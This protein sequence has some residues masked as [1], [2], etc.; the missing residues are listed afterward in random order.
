MM[1]RHLAALDHLFGTHSGTRLTHTVWL[2]AHA[3][4]RGHTPQ[5]MA[6]PQ[7]SV[8]RN[9]W[10]RNGERVGGMHTHPQTARCRHH[11]LLAGTMM[12]CGKAHGQR[13]K[14]MSVHGESAHGWKHA[15]GPRL[16]THREPA[17]HAGR[18]L[19]GGDTGHRCAR[20]VAAVDGARVVCGAL[21]ALEPAAAAV[22]LGGASNGERGRC[23]RCWDR[24]LPVDG[25][26]RG[27][28]RPAQTNRHHVGPH[29]GVWHA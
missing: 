24:R 7:L 19:V 16:R 29:T 18:A 6:L 10:Q 3:K 2:A 25:G 28:P 20:G 23:M 14:V 8:W 12:L 27:L 9:C 11:P 26:T 1:V 15:S 4:P 22:G 5:L 21:A 13:A 17:H